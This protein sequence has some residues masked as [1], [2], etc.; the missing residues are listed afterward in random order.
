MNTSHFPLAVSLEAEVEVPAS[1]VVRVLF[2]DLAN[3]TM[4]VTKGVGVLAVQR[5]HT[6][7]V[8]DFIQPF[9]ANHGEPLLTRPVLGVVILPCRWPV[10]GG[11]LV[12]GAHLGHAP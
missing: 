3:Y 6:S 11:H 4:A 12:R 1:E 8:G 7:L 5:F 2:P 10:V 9:E